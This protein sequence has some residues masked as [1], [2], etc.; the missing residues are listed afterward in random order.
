[1]EWLD[2]MLACVVLLL[3]CMTTINQSD[4]GKRATL[5]YRWASGRIEM[6]RGTVLEN[7]ETPE[8]KAGVLMRSHDWT[9]GITSERFYPA[10]DIANY[11][12]HY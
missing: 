7:I 11:V 6:V 9:V 8:D 10:S 3:G 5:Y 12:V 1:M 2:A 4:K